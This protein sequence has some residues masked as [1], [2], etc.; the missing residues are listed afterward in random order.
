MYVCPIFSPPSHG[1]ISNLSTYLEFLC[2]G[3]ANKI[4]CSPVEEEIKT[5][6]KRE[7]GL[8]SGFTVQASLTPSLIYEN[9]I[10]F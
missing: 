7:T 4:I 1:L 5:R 8:N 10:Q 2:H 6:L 3:G 9:E